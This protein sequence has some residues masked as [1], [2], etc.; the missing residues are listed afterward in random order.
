[1]HKQ[2]IRDFKNNLDKFMDTDG[3]T[4]DILEIECTLLYVGNG[5]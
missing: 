2:V 3:S 5:T 4:Q 1:M